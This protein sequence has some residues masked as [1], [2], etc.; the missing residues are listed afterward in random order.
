MPFGFPLRMAGVY[1]RVCGGTDPFAAA[2]IRAEGLSPRVRG[3]LPDGSVAEPLPWSIPACA[4]EPSNC[5]MLARASTVYPRVCGGTGL[6]IA[7]RESWCGLSPRV[8]GNP[9][10]AN[11]QRRPNRSI[12][13]CAGEPLAP[14]CGRCWTTVYPRVCGGT[15]P[16]YP[17]FA[18]VRGLSP[19]VR[20]NLWA[21]ARFLP[22]ARS[23]PACA[24]EPP[25]VATMPAKPRV[26]PRVCGG[27][28][29]RGWRR[30]LQDGLS[31]R[32]RGNRNAG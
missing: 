27:T 2:A 31:P 8:R 1:P 30:M 28:D 15:A 18:E 16:V 14:C 21:T 9:L 3:N 11:W 22:A 20:G 26:Y 24:G 7:M 17:A 32:V 25:E 4:G 5:R 6:T 10:R 23:I 12:P 19:R 13:A 29:T